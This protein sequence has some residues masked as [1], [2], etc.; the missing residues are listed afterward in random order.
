LQLDWVQPFSM[1][2]DTDGVTFTIRAQS[3]TY[4]GKT[5]KC[6]IRI[7]AKYQLQVSDTTL[8]GLRQGKVEVAC[9]AGAEGSAQ[10]RGKVADF[11]E[12]KFSGF[13]EKQVFLD[14]IT[15]PTG[16]RWNSLNTYYVVEVQSGPGWLY[17]AIREKGSG[18]TRLVQQ[19]LKAAEEK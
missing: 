1:H 8:N 14:G 12:K 3:I 5:L 6:P 2:I 19:M 18:A 13:F 4:N 16:E 9:L 7:D 15:I 11:L 10:V 17:L